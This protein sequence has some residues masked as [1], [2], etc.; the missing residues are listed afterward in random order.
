MTYFLLEH[1]R[2]TRRTHVTP[3]KDRDE[4]VRELNERE[5]SRERDV[6]V[7]LLIAETEGNLRITHPRYFWDEI[8]ESRVSATDL[9]ERLAELEAVIDR[10]MRSDS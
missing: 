3:F 10:R 1:N 8:R 4:S 6:D 5:A 2:R 7:V 9:E